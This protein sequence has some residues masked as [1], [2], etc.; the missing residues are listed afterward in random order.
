MTLMAFKMHYLRQGRNLQN[1][2]ER[3]MYIEAVLIEIANLQKAVERD[4]YLRQL[5][6]EFSLSLDALKQEQ[7]RLYREKKSHTNKEKKSVIQV[8]QQM[9]QPKK[10]LPAHHNAERMLIAHMMKD[11]HVA[12][13]VQ[14]KLGG[15]FYIDEHQ[16]LA[17]YLFAYYAKGYEADPSSF[18]GQLTDDRLIRLATELAMLEVNNE[19]EE[20]ELNDYMTLIE[21]YPKRVEIE[22]KELEV[23]KEKDPIKAAMMLTEIHQLKQML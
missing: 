17:A 18:I 1:E 21:N 15:A 23:K 12:E 22:Q 16:A 11:E 5:A 10:L 7:Y 13:L 3:M 4:H 19:Y 8:R 2:S 20:Q 9:F 14:E 6:D